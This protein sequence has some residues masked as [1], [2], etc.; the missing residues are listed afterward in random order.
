M[1]L[2]KTG[3]DI[4]V[5]LSFIKA[6]IGRKDL[7]LRMKAKELIKLI[8]KDGWYIVRQR[9]AISNTSILIKKVL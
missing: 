8:E 5:T 2:S 4:K 7:N 9:E 6:I 3:F 1:K